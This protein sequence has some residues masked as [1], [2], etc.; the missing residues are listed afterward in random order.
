MP[1]INDTEE[2]AL[3][4]YNVTARRGNESVTIAP[5]KATWI[6]VWE[7]EPASKKTRVKV[8]LDL[9]HG[10]EG[11]EPTIDAEGTYSWR[12]VSWEAG[13]NGFTN[14]NG[15][16]Y[17]AIKPGIVAHARGMIQQYLDID[18]TVVRRAIVADLRKDLDNIDRG[19][20]RAEEDLV[21]RR[22]RRSEKEAEIA[23]LEVGS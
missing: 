13:K 5:Y 22:K 10:P 2:K 16:A 11:Q 1:I 21:S 15:A 9:S 8:E 7:G 20:A 6:G 18:P 4:L 23:A 14:R 3:T 12:I 19:I 17:K